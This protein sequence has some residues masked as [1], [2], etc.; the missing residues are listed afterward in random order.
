MKKTKKRS[1]SDRARGAAPIA[2]EVV[3]VLEQRRGTHGDFSTNATVTQGIMCL[4]ATGPSWGNLSD[5]HVEALH[6]IAHK[7]AR[8]VCGDPAEPDH[9]ADIS[10]YARLVVKYLGGNAS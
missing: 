9:F 2:P 3:D 5:V 4:L 6:M 10:G 1:L 7:M 8:V